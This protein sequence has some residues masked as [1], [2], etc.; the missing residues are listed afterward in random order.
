MRNAFA[1]VLTEKVS[2]YPE[3][4]L[5][6]GDI[7]NQ[8]FDK[9]KEKAPR[10]FFNCGIAEAN[11]IGVAAGL[12]MTGFRPFVYTITP[13]VTLRCMEQIR[14][15]LCYH[16]VPVTFVGTGA[17]LSYAEL[18]PTHHSLDDIGTLRLFPNLTIMTPADIYELEAAIT[19]ILH[20]PIDAGPVY[21]RIGKKN[22]PT[23]HQSVPQIE[24]GKPLLLQ[25]TA[26]KCEIVIFSV[27]N[28]GKM[29]CDTAT[30]LEEHG[31]TVRVVSF[32]TI[33]PLSDTYLRQACAEH[34]CVV[35]ME[36]HSKISGLGSAVAEWIVDN[37]IPIRLLRFGTEDQFLKKMYHQEA[38]R[39]LFGLT[40]ANIA[41]TIAQRLQR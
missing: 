17:G 34:S 22:E 4:L 27:G 21:L 23:V 10:N 31:F 7:G 29:S 15:D 11:M 14:N 8:L 5:L 1:R 36:E 6:M 19:A 12:A 40:S 38:A 37:D 41:S 9:F 26:K 2:D 24:I 28:M 30:I 35:T 25:E 3:L 39:A 18:G 13:F 32:H 33:K 20:R 16:N